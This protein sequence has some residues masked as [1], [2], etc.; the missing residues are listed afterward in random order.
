MLVIEFLGLFVKSCLPK[1]FSTVFDY[2]LVLR[3]TVLS[4]NHSDSLHPCIVCILIRVVWGF[5]S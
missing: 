2:F 1:I 5:N 3:C 4:F